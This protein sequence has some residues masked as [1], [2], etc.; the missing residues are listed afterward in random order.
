MVLS[1]IFFIGARATQ[2][3][4][5]IPIIGML[6]YIVH[7][8]QAANQLTPAYVLVLFIVSVMAGVWCLLTLLFFLMAR[9]NAYFLAFID[10]CFFIGFIAGV[11][12]LRNI[13]NTSCTDLGSDVG[14][15]IYI[16]SGVFVNNFGSFCNI[17]KAAFGLSILEI[18]FFIWST[19]SDADMYLSETC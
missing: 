1:G 2:L 12:T 15:Q 4:F 11:A 13:A 7:G 10:F 8:Y 3:F 16:E 5:L 9:H 14:K 18:L 6:S 17:L 19:V